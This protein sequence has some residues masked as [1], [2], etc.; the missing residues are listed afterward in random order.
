MLKGTSTKIWSALA[1]AALAIFAG[2]GTP[3]AATP[4]DTL[5]MAKAIDDIVTLDPAEVYEFTGGEIINN[6]Y[7]RIMTF[8]PKDYTKVIGGA[9]RSYSVSADGLTLTFKM[10]KGIKFPSGREM[11]ATDAAFSLQR[12]VILDKTPAFILTQF[13]WTKDNVKQMITAPDNGTLVLKISK[14]FAP[15]FVLNCLTSGVASVVDQQEVM[16]H[17]QGGDLGYAWLKS[18]SAGSGA[19][20]IDAWNAKDS[21]VMHANPHFHGGAIKMKRVVLKHVAESTAQRL[22]VEKGDVDIARNL[23]ADQ[24]KAI[25]SDK[26]LVVETEPKTNIYYFAVSVKDPKLANPKVQQALRWL[27]DYQGM[28]KTFLAGQFKV[29]QAWWGS[30][31][32]GALDDTPFHLDVAKAKALLAEAG[33][34]NGFP[35]DVDVA[36]VAPFTDMAQSLQSTFAQAGI[37]VNL[38]QSDQ[39]QVITKY[40]ARKHQ[41]VLLYWSPD[42][43]DPHSTAD[44]FARNPDNSDNA[45]TKTI[46]W[47]NSWQDVALTKETDAALLEKDAKKRMA[48][49]VD[50]QRKMQQSGPIMV[51]FQQNEQAVLRKNVKHFILGPSFDTVV[52]WKVT[53]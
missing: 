27:I 19:Y 41:A 31:S 7:D 1:G 42:Y 3:Q 6:L 13:G 26:N 48:D 29:H 28:A 35:L 51:M 39:R 36:N 25:A 53:K 40:R 21:V 4:K 10:R 17:E 47:R 33:F 18:H 16:K 12:V 15:T 38:I 50:I 5:V 44:Y 52:Y 30:G 14:P 45:K 34:P 43:L 2:A 23:T 37:K 49:Y 8:D 20:V 32:A 9:T 46:A 11:T 22:L 24:I